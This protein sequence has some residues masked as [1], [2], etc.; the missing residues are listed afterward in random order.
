MKKSRFII[1]ALIVV[2]LFG[3]TACD[4]GKT[5]TDKEKYTVTFDYNYEGAPDSATAEVEEGKA[6]S[7]PADP[8]RTGYEFEGWFTDAACTEGKEYDFA[9]SVTQNITLYADWDVQQLTVTFNYNYNN[10]PASTVVSVDYNT[11]VTAPEEPVRDGYTFLAW[12]VAADTDNAEQFSFFAP[13]T[14]DITLYAGWF[15]GDA[16]SLATITYYMNIKGD[17][18]SVYM[19]TKIQKGKKLSKPADPTYENKRF[20]NWYQDDNCTDRVYFPITVK[21]SMDLYAYWFELYVYEAEHT[22][23]DDN[24]LGND[25]SGEFRGKEIIKGQNDYQNGAEIG[26]SNGYFIAGMTY[27]GATI[28]FTIE[29]DKTV[30]NAVL[31]LR[32]SP[33]HHDTYLTSEDTSGDPQNDY[34]TW[35]VVVNGHNLNYGKLDLTDSYGSGAYG[36]RNKRPFQDYELQVKLTLTEGMNVIKLVTENDENYGGTIQADAPL[37]DCIKIYTDAKLSWTK[38]N[39]DY[40]AAKG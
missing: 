27:N 13:I 2:L 19:T 35:S 20:E 5:N 39:E 10:A 11:T 23:I 31:I 6:V 37:I 9:S 18:Q 28:T 12:Y 40:I 4:N 26:A 25:W 1:L 22:Y 21:E 24:M 15:E 34:K 36:E 14:E 32:L 16:S 29:S 33:D 8:T 38:Y 30:E 3:L 7:K 17:E